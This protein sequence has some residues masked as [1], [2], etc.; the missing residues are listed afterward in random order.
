M[1]P[2]S[3]T[4]ISRSSSLF[5]PSAGEV[6][7]RRRPNAHPGQGL[8]LGGQQGVK[9]GSRTKS[10]GCLWPPS[11]IHL[12]RAPGSTSSLITTAGPR[13]LSPPVKP[14]VVDDVS[15]PITINRKMVS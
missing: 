10:V 2:P 9:Q 14:T 5:C 3:D 8:L 7:E 1:P 12:S 15:I 13:V 6:E 11:S 4:V